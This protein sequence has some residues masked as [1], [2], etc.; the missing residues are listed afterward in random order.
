MYFRKKYYFCHPLAPDGVS[1]LQPVVRH[2]E[3][4]AMDWM[5][6]FTLV[7]GVAYIY[8]E[9]RQKDFMWIVGLVTSAAAVYVF[10]E[11][12]LYATAALNVYYLAVSFWGL[13]QWRRD[14]RSLGKDEEGGEDVIHLRHL[15]V[16]TAAVSA[17]IYAVS[18]VLLVFLMEKLGDAMSSLDAAVTVLGAVGTWWLSRSYKEQWLLWI[19]ADILT[20]VMCL[21]Q[22][23]YYMAALYVVYTACAAYG[24]F[25]WKRC[26]IYISD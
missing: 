23:M 17:G 19:V 4:I 12:G 9:V 3:A 22:G 5:E 8:L 18:T 15:T 6:I 16:R 10:T 25:H 14:R 2:S 20:A 13:Y 7:T 21:M 26:G 11:R 1:V 24:Y